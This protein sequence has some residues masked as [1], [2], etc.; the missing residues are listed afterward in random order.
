MAPEIH[1]ELEYEAQKTDIFSAG[2]VLFILMTKH[3]PISDKA[4]ESDPFYKLIIANWH[5]LFWKCHSWSKPNGLEFYGWDL[6]NLISSMLMPDPSHRP[7]LAEILGHPWMQGEIATY[8]E[9]R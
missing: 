6:M 2:V 5:D 8:E 4:V 9:V 1:K 3:F 7:S